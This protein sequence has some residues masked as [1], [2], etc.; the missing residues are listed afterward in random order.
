MTAM[1][2]DRLMCRVRGLQLQ[3]VGDF[4]EPA[5]AQQNQFLKKQNPAYTQ[6]RLPE[7]QHVAAVP[8]PETSNLLGPPTSPEHR[9][10]RSS[11]A[12]RAEARGRTRS[13]G[14]FAFMFLAS[15][16]MR[17]IDSLFGMATC[18]IA[19]PHHMGDE[20]ARFCDEQLNPEAYSGSTRP[21][22]SSSPGPHAH[23][24]Q[25]LAQIINLPNCGSTR[26]GESDNWMEP[27]SNEGWRFVWATR[28][29][30]LR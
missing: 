26:Y 1:L 6:T 23:A 13:S 7:A 14:A 22:R 25:A 30:H 12:G 15:S 9:S 4:G 19:K 20:A 21:C 29:L 28:F 10:C 18:R 3:P 11:R 27:C 5:A 17:S 8:R 2:P 16:V 24:I